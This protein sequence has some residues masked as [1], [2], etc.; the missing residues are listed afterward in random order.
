MLTGLIAEL[1]EQILVG[2]RVRES[3]KFREKKSGFKHTV[4]SG[5]YVKSSN[6]KIKIVKDQAITLTLLSLNGWQ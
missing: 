6:K 2:L 1:V 4:F 3:G 5:I